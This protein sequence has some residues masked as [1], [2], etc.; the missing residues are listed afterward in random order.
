M[1]RGS[2][3]HGTADGYTNHR[4]RCDRC[5]EAR[6]EQLLALTKKPD[7]PHGTDSLYTAGCRCDLCREAHVAA[8]RAYRASKKA[9]RADAILEEAS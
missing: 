8:C 9:L 2:F 3:R 4:C 1:S 6:K 7:A 5:Y